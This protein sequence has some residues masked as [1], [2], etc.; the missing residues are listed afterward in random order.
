[1]EV[2]RQGSITAAAR[3]LNLTQPAVSQ[4]IAGLEVAVGRPL[5]VR[6]AAGV[7][8]TAAADELAADVG[9]K[10]D[11]AESALASARA[12][13]VDVAGALQIIGHADFLAEV[14]CERL[15][16]LLSVGVRIRMQAA[17]QDLIESMLVEG[18]CDLGISAFATL[19]KRLR[20]ELI[21]AENVMVV[22]PPSVAQRILAAPTLRQGLVAEPLLAYSLE[23]PLIDQWLERNRLAGEPLQ[24]AVIGQ[25]LRALRSV[26]RSGFGWT[27]LPGYL[28]QPELDRGELVEIPA[29]HARGQLHYYLV[30]APSALRTPRV[31]HARQAILWALGQREG[32]AATAPSPSRQA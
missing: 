28:C 15:R 21:W 27:A 10:L 5:F 2:Y 30:W 3:A 13:S 24:P 18:H 26:L 12:R 1:M 7:V 4:H 17:S 14:V 6:N 20:C 23:L 22:A 32:Q 29:P 19:D 8:P 11:A 9:D 25:D 16:D 31:A